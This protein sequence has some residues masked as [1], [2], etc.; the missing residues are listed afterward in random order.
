MPT[1]KTCQLEHSD[2]PITSERLDTGPRPIVVRFRSK[3]PLYAGLP[4]VVVQEAQNTLVV[5]ITC[6]ES[7]HDGKI[8]EV[9]GAEV[10][11][12]RGNKAASIKHGTTTHLG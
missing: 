7:E 6:P 9:T 4:A 10:Y 3:D 5:K 2:C 1:C 12:S 11:L 8:I